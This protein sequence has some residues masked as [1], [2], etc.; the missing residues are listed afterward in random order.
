[1][2]ELTLPIKI[3]FALMGLGFLFHLIGFSAPYW[4]VH[5]WK[6][7]GEHRVN[8]GLW[9]FCQEERSRVRHIE[10][11]GDMLSG[12]YGTGTLYVTSVT[13]NVLS[14]THWALVVLLLYGWCFVTY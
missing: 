1:M 11:C 10:L 5:E 13:D 2:A 9:R 3:A 4:H 6:Y 12:A 8:Y 7:M 14:V